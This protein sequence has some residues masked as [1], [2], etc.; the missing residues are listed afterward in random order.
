VEIEELAKKRPGAIVRRTLD[1]WK[2]LLAYQARQLAFELGLRGD[3]AAQAAKVFT[4][5]AQAFLTLDASL[6]EINP[7]VV[8]VQGRVFCID[9]KFNVDD[10]ALFRHPEVKDLVLPGAMDEREERAKQ[11]GLSYVSLDGRI[12]CLVNG[13]GLAMATMDIIKLHGGEPANFLDVGGGANTEAVTEA[14]QLI[15]SD[16]KVTAILNIFGGIMKCD[17]IAN[18]IVEAVKKTALRVP[19][20]VRLEGTNV[21]EGKAILQRSGLNITSAKD[22][23]EAAQLVVRASTMAVSGQR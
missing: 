9:A 3:P 17:V 20:V 22:L 18:G 7:L 14:F 12:G 15:M 8:T 21:E 2:G 1:P 23:N 16:P 10:N 6:A 13:A 5:L 19:L 11:F 4:G